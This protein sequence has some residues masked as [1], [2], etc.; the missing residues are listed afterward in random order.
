MESRFLG[1]KACDYSWG[2]LVASDSTEYGLASQGQEKYV[3]NRR[4]CALKTTSLSRHVSLGS[5]L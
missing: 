1:L 5:M 3:F 2:L 4:F